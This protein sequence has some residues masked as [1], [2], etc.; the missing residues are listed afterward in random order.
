MPLPSASGN[1]RLFE[2]MIESGMGEL[3]NSAVV[4]VIERLA[5]VNLLDEA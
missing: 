5:G 2:Q 4:G 3:D 1:A